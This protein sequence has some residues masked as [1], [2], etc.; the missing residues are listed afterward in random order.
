MLR[1]TI[2]PF[3]LGSTE[4]K[5]TAHAGLAL[6]D[7]C[8][9]ALGLPEAFAQEFPAP[10]SNRGFRPCEFGRAL[11]MILHGGGRTFEDLRVLE[12]DEGLKAALELTVPSSDAAREWTGRSG[13]RA[14]EAACGR[15]NRTLLKKMRRQLKGKKLTFDLD[16]TFNEAHKRTAKMSYHGAPGYYPMTGWISDGEGLELCAGYEYRAGNESPKAGNRE[17]IQHCEAQLPPGARIA[18]LR[19]DSAAFNSDVIGYCQ[20]SATDFLIR[21]AQD[22]AVKAVSAAIPED[23]WRK[24]PKDLGEGEYA[25]TVH[26]FA[27][28]AQAFR[29]IAIRRPLQAVLDLREGLDI[30]REPEERHFAIATSLDNGACA[31]IRLYNQRGQ[32]ENLIKELKLGYAMEYTPTGDF[33]SNAV[34]FGLGCIA[35]N[36]GQALK[37]LALDESWARHTVATLRWRLY[38]RAAKLVRHAGQVLLLLAGGD[39]LRALFERVRA[40]LFAV[41]STA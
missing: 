40:A 2:L 28:S 8:A 31:V 1:Q 18:L 14:G 17:F 27:K 22:T 34:W 7:E 9:S 10:G 36:I 16:A 12:Q 11:L 20:T 39:E 6:V 4:Q 15:V 41:Y 13:G 21:A 35:F 23:D 33:G 24:L 38:Q 37:L 5:L 3:K 19:S 26:C 30:E 29:L 25:E 32:A